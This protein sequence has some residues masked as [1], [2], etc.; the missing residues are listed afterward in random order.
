MQGSYQAALPLLQA[1]LAALERDT[2]VVGHGLRAATLALYA[3]EEVWDETGGARAARLVEAHERAIGV[4]GA[5]RST[6]VVRSTWELRAGRFATATAC[7][8]E[9]QDLAAVIGQP[10]PAWP[11]GWSSWPGAARSRRPVR[12]RI[13]SYAIWPAGTRTAV[14]PT[15]PGT[16]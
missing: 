4:L 6:L 14:W 13:S 11:T 12:P 1:A 8:D 3:A 15:G 10:S 5:L 2:D 7:L 9:A 16:A